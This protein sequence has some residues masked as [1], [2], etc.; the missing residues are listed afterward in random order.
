MENSPL[1][2]PYPAAFYAL[3]SE[4]YEL[5][6]LGF[7]AR[8]TVNGNLYFVIIAQRIQELVPCWIAFTLAVGSKYSHPSDSSSPCPPAV[9][10]WPN[11]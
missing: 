1:W 9:S 2:L 5:H 4:K 10:L 6:N 8:R 7:R 11:A 3:H